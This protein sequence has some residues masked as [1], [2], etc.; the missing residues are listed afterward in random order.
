MT[1]IDVG[2]HEHIR[3]DLGYAII[4]EICRKPLLPKLPANAG[5][6]YLPRDP[7]TGFVDEG[8]LNERRERAKRYE[9]KFG[10]RGR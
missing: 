2:P 8:E 4:C 7:Q 1:P 5:E 9:A 10:K 6:E 3:K